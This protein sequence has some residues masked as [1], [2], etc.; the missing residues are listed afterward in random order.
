MKTLSIL[1]ALVVLTGCGV[2]DEYRNALPTQDS[3]KINVPQSAGQALIGTNKQ[4]LQ[5]QTA[6]FYTFTVDISGMVNGAT[7]FVLNLLQDVTT[8]QPTSESGDSAVWGPWAD[9]LSANAY[10]LTVT[11]TAQATYSYELDGKAKTAPDSAFLAL[12]TGSA[13]AT[14]DGNNKPVPGFGSGSFTMN[15]D[16]TS[17]LPQNDGN[18]G[19]GAFQY[20]RTSATAPASV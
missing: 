16:N 11:K 13:V 18:V 12:L 9:P 15:W 6:T 1:A 10:R 4:G 8:Y 5:G 17:Q 20:S 19:T 2:N 7:V 3:A 14:L